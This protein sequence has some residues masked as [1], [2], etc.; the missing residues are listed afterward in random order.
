MSKI[1]IRDICCITENLEEAL[2]YCIEYEP[3]E[4]V[5]KFT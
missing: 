4:L 5:D 1:N 3:T 2:Q